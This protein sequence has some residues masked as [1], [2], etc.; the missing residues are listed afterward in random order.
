MTPEEKRGLAGLMRVTAKLSADRLALITLLER[1]GVEDWQ[2]QLSE[3]RTSDDYR[4]LLLRHE[5]TIRQTEEDADLEA[6]L[7]LFEQ[8]QKGKPPN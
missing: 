2:D 5:L 6:L 8:M 7:P 3:L 4:A 1:A